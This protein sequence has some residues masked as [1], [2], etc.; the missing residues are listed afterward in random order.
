[1]ARSF[2]KPRGSIQAKVLGFIG[3]FVLVAIAIQGYLFYK[4]SSTLKRQAEGTLLGEAR[5]VSESVAN[6]FAGRLNDIRTFSGL[7]V[8]NLALEI[9]GGQGGTDQF[10]KRIVAQYPYYS[11]MMV[12]N[13]SGKVLS[14]SN[15][16]FVGKNF[17]ERSWFS[18]NNDGKVSMTGPIL[19]SQVASARGEGSRFE[20]KYT[21]LFIAPIIKK[22]KVAGALLAFINWQSLTDLIIAAGGS[23]L[24]KGGAAYLI[25]S[26]GKIFIHPDA[27]KIGMSLASLN[28]AALAAINGEV[29]EFKDNDKIFAT[30]LLVRL[31]ADLIS[32]VKLKA[33]TEL[34]ANAVMGAL[35]GLWLHMLLGNI[36]L[37]L[38]LIVLVY[39]LNRNV[40]RPIVRT[41]TLLAETAHDMDLR[42]RIDVES[43]D[44]VGMMGAAVNDFLES[45]QS[46]F[47]DITHLVSNLAGATSMVQKHS[48]NIVDNAS[49]QVERAKEVENRVAI[50]GRTAAEVAEHA[51]SSSRLAREAAQ[52][53]Q[54]LTRTTQE[55]TKISAD[56][57]KG[58]QQAVETVEAMGDT[59]KE[60]QARAVAQADAA[61]ETAGA[62]QKMASELQQ[63][64]AD[65]Q[66]AASQ[67]EATKRSAQ[68]GEQAMHETVQTMEVIAGSSEQ[69]R[70]IVDLISDI[71]EQT[72]LLALNAAIEAARAGEHGRG[73][74]V[75]AEEIRKLA[76]RTGESAKEIAVLIEESVERVHEGLD[77]TKATAAA[78]EKILESVESSAEV[79]IHMSQSSSEQADSTQ[80]LLKETEELKSLAGS[81]V[82]MTEKQAE[83]RKRAARV[84]ERLKEF[85]EEITEAANTSQLTTKT[86]VETITK[87]VANSA[88]ITSRTAKQRERSEG[89]KEIMATMARV[90]EVNAERAQEA[91]EAVEKML[92]QAQDMERKIQQFKI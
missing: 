56:N 63:M 36:I 27:E 13:K 8:V 86:S 80:A 12:V 89:L 18:I 58:A 19:T 61:T 55:I 74:A 50:M 62:L 29:K 51:E 35:K 25:D 66:G 21:S 44:E 15:P 78:L 69:V 37:F 53:I 26:A 82:N 70:E 46:T 75:V 28:R 68:D 59:A 84:I 32:P 7:D 6:F 79:I 60:V 5:V 81:I 91:L 34:P 38:M 14:A 4:A 72:N 85:S 71:A 48:K 9:G 49:N 76:E 47:K 2:S 11:A 65:A 67:A 10:L 33:V 54:D 45:L 24:D 16:S 87:V 31:P 83:R 30:A 90:A 40:V 77:T 42:R 73:F 1:M 23:V 52:I 22:D 20:H 17:R 92:R 39:L 3:L 43:N 41:S 88:E 64:A 57:Q